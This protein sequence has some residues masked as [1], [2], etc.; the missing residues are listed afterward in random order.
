MAEEKDVEMKDAEAVEK[1]IKVPEQKKQKMGKVEK[2]SD[3][4]EEDLE[5][6]A[7]LLTVIER[8][9]KEND[10]AIQVISNAEKLLPVFAFWRAQHSEYGDDGG[11]RRLQSD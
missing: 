3:P 10:P 4:S 8:I 2:V 7:I 5:L 1:D 9:S 11:M 6:K